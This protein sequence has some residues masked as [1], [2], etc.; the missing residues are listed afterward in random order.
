ML[1]F[2]TSFKRWIILTIGIG[3]RN[4]PLIHQYSLYF[5][6]I[7]MICSLSCVLIG[8]HDPDNLIYLK[9]NRKCVCRK[10]Y[11][12]YDMFC[13]V[14]YTKLGLLISRAY[15]SFLIE[16]LL[17]SKHCVKW[18]TYELF[19]MFQIWVS[20]KGNGIIRVKICSDVKYLS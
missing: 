12:N 18:K 11:M 6:T 4:V 17:K 3:P 16:Q 7:G 20:R 8:R 19:L 14:S 5:F 1:I 15:I 13:N 10:S 9:K 2:L